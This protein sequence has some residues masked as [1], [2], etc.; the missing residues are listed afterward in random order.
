VFLIAV[1]QLDPLVHRLDRRARAQRFAHAARPLDQ[2]RL[3]AAG[4]TTKEKIQDGL[5]NI[6][7]RTGASEVNLV[8]TGKTPTVFVS[9][10]AN[11]IITGDDYRDVAQAVAR[12]RPHPVYSTGWIDGVNYVQA[13][14]PFRAGGERYVLAIR[15]KIDEIPRA[16]HAVAQAFL[17]A[18][19]AAL[20]LALLLG[21]PLSARI[22]R[23]L[24]RLR[25][26]AL[27]LA[28][29]GQPVDVP[30][31]RA[32]DEVADLARTF[33]LMQRQL[34]RPEG[35]RRAFVATASHEFPTPLASLDGMPELLDEDFRTGHPDPD[36]A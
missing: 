1:W 10:P 7:R 9:W 12:T 33:A 36:P 15:K 13:A 35:A 20:G 23:R 21:I 26:A 16:V 6:Y 29:E 4:E 8:G 34:L 11:S 30:V 17:I 2:R 25:E 28:T 18:A 5:E 24:R 27:R 3:A 22:V 19:L 32:R 31:D 14:L